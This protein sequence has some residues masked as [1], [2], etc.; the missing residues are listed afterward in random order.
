MENKDF[1]K[2]FS[3]IGVLASKESTMIAE[4]EAQTTASIICYALDALSEFG[5]IS[6]FRTVYIMKCIRDKF[7]TEDS[8]GKEVHQFIEDVSTLLFQ[9]NRFVW[10]FGK[11]STIIKE[12]EESINNS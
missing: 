4:Y 3:E 6:D 8:T 12:Y 2:V 7:D 11:I 5:G 10:D 9:S 1:I